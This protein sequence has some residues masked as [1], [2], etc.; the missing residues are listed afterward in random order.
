MEVIEHEIPCFHKSTRTTTA[1]KTDGNRIE[2]RVDE[3]R[4]RSWQ[5]RTKY[6][7]GYDKSGGRSGPRFYKESPTGE[8]VL[9]HSLEF[10]YGEN[11]VRRSL[12]R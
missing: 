10:E 5:M 1:F 11:K 7:C 3:M 9:D 8:G 6:V 4:G 2:H 12:Q